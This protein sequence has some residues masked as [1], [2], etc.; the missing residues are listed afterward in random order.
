MLVLAAAVPGAMAQTALPDS[1]TTLLLHTFPSGN[2][3][4][5]G[6]DT[7]I[8][9]PGGIGIQGDS[10]SAWTLATS[11]TVTGGNGIAVQFGSAD[12]TMTVEGARLPVRSS[13]AP[14]ET[15]S[16]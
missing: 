8:N 5:V 3:F 1:A 10:S 9:V 16:P 2:P 6:A 4:T 14:A 12:D 7:T 11:G 13:R 15:R